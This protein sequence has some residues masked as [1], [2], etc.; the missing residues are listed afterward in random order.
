LSRS[1]DNARWRG[2]GGQHSELTMNSHKISFKISRGTAALGLFVIGLASMVAAA[3]RPASAQTMAAAATRFLD[4]LTPDQRKQAMFALESDELTR[5]HF[6]P[7]TSFPRNGL[8]IKAM[9]EPQ[10]EL[11]RGL[12]KAALSQGG[13]LTATS[14]MDLEVVL[15][16][17]EGAGGTMVRD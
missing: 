7:T 6:I 1:L 14:I 13:Y 4:G 2:Y 11:A 15:K 3:Q 17:L 9:T 12:L 8:P 16:A 5:W 10:R